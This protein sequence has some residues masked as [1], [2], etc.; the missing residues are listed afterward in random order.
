MFNLRKTHSNSRVFDV[1]LVVVVAF[2]L[3]VA[4]LSFRA[5]GAWIVLGILALVGEALVAWGVFVEEFRLV[6]TSYRER[7][8]ADPKAWIKIAFVSDLHAGAFHDEE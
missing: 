2:G 1:A 3:T 7:L 8:V 5:G 6:V 4:W